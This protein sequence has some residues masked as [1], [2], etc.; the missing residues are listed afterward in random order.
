MAYKCKHFKIHELVPEHIVRT[1][2]EAAWE[3]IDDRLAMTLDALRESLGKSITVNNY[4]WGGNRRWSGLRTAGYYASLQAYE[5]SLSQHKYGRAAD[6]IVAGMDANAVRE[7]IYANK[8]KFPYIS[9][10][11][12][13]ITWVHIDVRN[14]DAITCWSPTR[15]YTGVK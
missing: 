8:H 6:F 1:R 12:V 2:G 7:H 5:N 11:E 3:L 4:H 13:D 9:F 15:G 10:V 14:C